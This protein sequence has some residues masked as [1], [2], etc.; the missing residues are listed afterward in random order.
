MAVTVEPNK[1]T[2]TARLEDTEGKNESFKVFLT[3]SSW[4]QSSLHFCLRDKNIS[5]K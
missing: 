2:K 1:R 3:P 5:A 4:Q